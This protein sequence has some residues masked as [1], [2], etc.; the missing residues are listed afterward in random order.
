M[1]KG[2]KP[3][4]PNIIL[5][6][7]GSLSLLAVALGAWV[8]ASSGVA[9]TVWGRNLA[10]WVIGAIAAYILS[11]CPGRWL[12]PALLSAA[13]LSLASTLVS[14]GQ[15]GVHRW[16]NIG[17]LAIN[18]AMLTLPAALV[19]L[20]ALIRKPVGVWLMP[21]ACMV[22]LA[23]QPDASQATA[24]AVG[25]IWIALALATHGWANWAAA[26]GAAVLA[27][28]SWTRPDPLEPV[29]EVEQIL[30]L[31]YAMSPALAG[32]GLGALVFFGLAPWRLVSRNSRDVQF[33]GGALSLYLLICSAMPFLGAFPVPLLGVGISPVL[34]AWFGIGALA[35]L[36]R[37]RATSGVAIQEN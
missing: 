1:F 8:C 9:A 36:S 32:L 30:Q 26:S 11:R 37:A 3:I 13:V 19:A 29:A 28:V 27:A 5:L 4:S 18:A 21:L 23:I 25:L 2:A 35:A 7:S 16:L 33:A 24:F 12:F 17:P 10:A 31:A 6:V 20:A 15:M 14:P 22:V 34:G